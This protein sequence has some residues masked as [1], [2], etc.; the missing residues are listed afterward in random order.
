MNVTIAVE[1]VGCVQAPGDPQVTEQTVHPPTIKMIDVA[2]NSTREVRREDVPPK[3]Q[4]VMLD[5]D[6]VE[7]DDPSL[8]VERIPILQVRVLKLDA[9]GKL[10]SSD[11]AVEMR[12]LEY[13]PDDRLLRSTTMRKD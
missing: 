12:I 7:T 1:C 3:Q 9:E 4:L 13:G 10:A 2:E 6:G 5:R 8:A 11:N